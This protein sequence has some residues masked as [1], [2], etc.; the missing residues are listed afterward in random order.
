MLARLTR[1]VDRSLLAADWNVNKALLLRFLLAT[2]FIIAA[3]IVGL[4]DLDP[5]GAI[6]LS[7]LTVAFLT[8]G[9]LV[10]HSIWRF[11]KGYGSTRRSA[12]NFSTAL[13]EKDEGPNG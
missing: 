12:R 9:A 10:F 2:P 7:V 1:L 8:S 6:T 13:R 11:F 5:N 4:L 3:M